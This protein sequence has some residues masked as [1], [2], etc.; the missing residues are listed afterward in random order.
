M[1]QNLRRYIVVQVPRLV[2]LAPGVE[3]PVHPCQTSARILNEGWTI[4]TQPGIIVL[5]WQ[6]LHMIA[7]P[8]STH[9]L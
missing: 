8:E 3:L 9:L 5:N 4:V 2:F 6:Q 7:K 1:L